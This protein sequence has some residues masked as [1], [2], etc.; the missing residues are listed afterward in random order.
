MST[1]KSP[2]LSSSDRLADVIAALQATA[3]YRFYQLRFDGDRGWA[4]R[5]AG[6]ATKSRRVSNGLR[7]ASGVLPA[8]Q[9][10]SRVAGVA[11]TTSEALRR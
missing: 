2:Y 8:R 4:W 9:P 10:R 5:I 1:T 11:A 7:K 3:T 6:N